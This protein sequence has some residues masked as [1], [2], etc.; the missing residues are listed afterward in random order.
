MNNQ[1]TPIIYII[2]VKIIRFNFFSD[3]QPENIY[4]IF[5]T[6]FILKLLRF[7]S[8]NDEHL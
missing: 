8:F 4:S 6:S 2:C 7:N 5:F 3:E 1:I